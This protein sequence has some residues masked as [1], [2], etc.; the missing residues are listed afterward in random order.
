MVPGMNETDACRKQVVPLLQKLRY[1]HRSHVA[2]PPDKIRQTVSGK[3]ALNFRSTLSNKSEA[4]SRIFSLDA[5]GV[6]P[7]NHDSVFRPRGLRG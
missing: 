3:S 2:F 7:S 6:C 4:L 1:M 5:L